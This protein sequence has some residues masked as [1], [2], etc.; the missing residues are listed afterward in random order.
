MSKPREEFIPADQAASPEPVSSSNPNT[1]FR[2]DLAFPT[3][4]GEMLERIRS[5]G[6]E[7]A[8]PKDTCL[9]T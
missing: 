2:S 8:V 6:Q 9:Y 4:S 7:E 1:E 5:Y 3:L